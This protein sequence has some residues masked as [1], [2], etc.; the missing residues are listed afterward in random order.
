MIEEPLS[1]NSS[2]QF[3]MS[4]HATMR[5]RQGRL[6]LSSA[7]QPKTLIIEQDL[8]PLLVGLVEPRSLSW[9]LG[10]RSRISRTERPIGPLQT[11]PRRHCRS[12]Q[13]TVLGTDERLPGGPPT[14]S[15]SDNA[16]YGRRHLQLLQIGHGFTRSASEHFSTDNWGRPLPWIARPVIDFLFQLDLSAL[17]AF[18]YG[19]GASTFYW[20]RRCASVVCVESDKGWADRLKAELGPKVRVLLRDEPRAY[21]SAILETSD[22]YDIILIDAAPTYRPECAGPAVERLSSRGMIILDDAPFYPETAAKL[23]AAGL[24]EVDMTGYSPLENNLQT[25]SLFLSKDFD[26]PRRAN[27]SPAFPFGSP[28]FH[29]DQLAPASKLALSS[30]PCWSASLPQRQPKRPTVSDI[31]EPLRAKGLNRAVDPGTVET[32]HPG[33]TAINPSPFRDSAR[34]KF[35]ALARRA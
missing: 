31:G 5:W 25:T 9:I 29:W 4:P 26:L 34:G 19:G 20:T 35:G 16:R 18:E 8:V 30:A 14:S 23:R 17:T 3:V 21:A 22:F 28:G 13:A 10:V 32:G 12:H 33:Q 2:A 6:L 11:A 1:P 27:R 15:R 7:R 24:I